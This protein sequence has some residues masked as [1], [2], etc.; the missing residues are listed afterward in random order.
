M[1]FESIKLDYLS[2]YV[3]LFALFS[4]VVERKKPILSVERRVAGSLSQ[5]RLC[6]LGQRKQQTTQPNTADIAPNAAS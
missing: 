5:D 4:F 2:L 6:V 1:E 3:V